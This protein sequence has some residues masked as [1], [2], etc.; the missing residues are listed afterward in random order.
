MK[1]CFLRNF[2]FIFLKKYIEKSEKITY[3]EVRKEMR[4]YTLC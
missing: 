3:N 4:R 2:Y 1:K